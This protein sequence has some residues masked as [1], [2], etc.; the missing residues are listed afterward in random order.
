MTRPCTPIHPCKGCLDNTACTDSGMVIV[1]GARRVN[2]HTG[3][4][5]YSALDPESGGFWV[6]FIVIAAICV[7]AF[8]VHV[9]VR[10]AL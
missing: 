4:D 6:G 7:G 8:L 5:E 1:P 3:E 2:T 9:A 10:A